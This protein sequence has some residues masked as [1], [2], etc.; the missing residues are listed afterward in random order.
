LRQ[1]LHLFKLQALQVKSEKLPYYPVGHVATQ[2][3]VADKYVKALQVTQL[4]I[5]PGMLQ[6]L[7]VAWQLLHSALSKYLPGIQ[8][9]HVSST[10]PLSHVAQFPLQSLQVLV[11]SSP[12]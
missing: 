4:L 9:K 11:I 12:Y 2:V 6:V 3:F 10:V 1:L 7:H 8:D 5:A